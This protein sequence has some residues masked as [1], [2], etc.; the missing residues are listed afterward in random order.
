[1]NGTID[2]VSTSNVTLPIGSNRTLE[3]E[4]L[5]LGSVSDLGGYWVARIGNQSVNILSVNMTSGR[6]ILGPAQGADK[7][8]TEGEVLVECVYVSPDGDELF[9]FNRSVNIESEFFLVPH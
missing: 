1:M 4:L 7:Y 8:E 6:A 5:P 3:C 9:S 2:G